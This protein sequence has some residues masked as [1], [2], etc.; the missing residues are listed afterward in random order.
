MDKPE[1]NDEV[2]EQGASALADNYLMGSHCQMITIT[3]LKR[4]EEDT[5]INR[6]ETGE[7]NKRGKDNNEW[8]LYFK[9]QLDTL[10]KPFLMWSATIMG[11]ERRRWVTQ[12]SWT[13]NYIMWG[14]QGN[15]HGRGQCSH[16]R[17]RGLFYPFAPS[18]WNNL[19]LALISSL[20]PLPL[21]PHPTIFL[22]PSSVIN[23]EAAVTQSM[24]TED[25]YSPLPM[26]D[27]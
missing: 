7:A 23:S 9:V 15:A 11:G 2:V 13:Q 24:T 25:I 21:F 8:G 4:G 12:L 27:K 1:A 17:N 16:V 6:G 18:F 5:H 22:L 14:V 26:Q 20:P 10:K 19:C 3:K